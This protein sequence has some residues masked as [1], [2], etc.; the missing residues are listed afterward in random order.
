[1]NTDLFEQV[2]TFI[3]E[4]S[5]VRKDRIF[6]ET[7]I[8]DDL[9]IDGADG[10]ELLEAFCARFGVDASTFPPHKYFG[11][12]AAAN[13]LSVILSIAR[14]VTTGS[15]SGLSPLTVRDL[16]RAIDSEDG[17]AKEKIRSE[18]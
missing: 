1:M 8:N 12:E 10:E 9:G 16:V 5:S 4:F 17:K 3:A 14:R 6:A 15:W 7:R 11:P 13:P 18:S 2:R